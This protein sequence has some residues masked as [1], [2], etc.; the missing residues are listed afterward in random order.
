MTLVG[1]SRNDKAKWTPPAKCM[2]ND[3]PSV[4][5]VLRGWK[6]STIVVICIDVGAGFVVKLS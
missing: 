4:M 2:R 3:M 1:D 6:T 5:P